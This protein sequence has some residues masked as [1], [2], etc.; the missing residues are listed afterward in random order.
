[1]LGGIGGRRRRD[2]RGW[3]GWMASLTRWTWVWV[4]LG[5]GDG[6][7]GLVCCD[8]WRCRVGH[9]WVTELNWT[10]CL[11]KQQKK[12]KKRRRRRRRERRRKINKNLSHNFQSS[13]R[14]RGYH[15]FS[16][17]VYFIKCL[18][19]LSFKC[20]CLQHES[21]NFESPLILCQKIHFYNMICGECNEFHCL[22]SSF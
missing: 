5:V 13:I 12:K 16:S 3:N 8:S 6:Q 1:M 14:E 4:N 21:Q 15:H 11:W 19:A 9:D 22:I 7:G 10:E 2:D 18:I 20:F 17:Y